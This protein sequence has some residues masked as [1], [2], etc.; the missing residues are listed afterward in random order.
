MLKKLFKQT[1]KAVVKEV[2]ALALSKL[3]TRNLISQ[4]QHTDL[5]NV[6]N[7]INIDELIK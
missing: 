4:T 3:L 2:F 1:I 7:E 6:F 5:T